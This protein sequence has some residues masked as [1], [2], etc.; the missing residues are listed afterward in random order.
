MHVLIVL[1]LLLPA[2]QPWPQVTEA[3]FIAHDF[4]FASGETMP[5][6]RIH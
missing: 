3:D 2:P 5:E 4:R 6:L 1:A